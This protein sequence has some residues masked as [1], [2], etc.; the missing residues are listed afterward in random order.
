M[1]ANDRPVPITSCVRC[2]G[3][4]PARAAFC[5][6]CGASQRD[7]APAGPVLPG[8]TVI[9]RLGSGGA[10]DVYLAC[11]DDLDREV[12]I[13][14]L[15]R[16]VDDPKQWRR[17][18]RE[19]QTIARLSS[20]PH[21]VTVHTA[22]RAS[23]GQPYLV[24]E[25]LDRGSLGD[26]V[27]A[28]GPLAP[29]RAARVGVAVADALG[30]AHELGI[31]HRDVK[32]GN[33]LLAD[34]G[35]VKLG[36]FGI[37]RLLEAQSVTVT[38]VIA[39]TPEHVPPELLRNEPDGPWSDVY[40][41]AST[42]A[43]ALL[44]RSLF[45]M[46]PDERVD[47]FLARKVTSPPPALP[48]WVPPVLAEPI[49]AALD[50]DPRRRP[51]LPE[52]RRDLAAAADELSRGTSGPAAGTPPEHVLPTELLAPATATGGPAGR[53][54]PPPP[55]GSPPGRGGL[56]GDRR[57]RP[58]ARPATVALVS[59]LA[60]LALGAL[61][62][63]AAGLIGPDDPEAAIPSTTL[64]PATTSVP[65]STAPAADAPAAAPPTPVTSSP[66][67]TTPAATTSR[68]SGPA[69]LT[70]TEAATYLRSYYDAVAAG[71]YERTWAQLA[72]EFQTGT[73]RSFDYYVGFWEENDI[74]VGDVELVEADAERAVVDA[75]LR[76]NGSAD[77]V[78]ARFTLRPGADGTLLIADQETITD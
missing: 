44:A 27:A 50:P 41:L 77:A 60:L 45:R 56:G 37:A 54:P 33:V 51:S 24:T 23:T 64:G 18:Q 65:V 61:A 69:L 9:R 35:R 66:S 53:R 62:A 68:P 55:G 47:A 6:H 2:H 22:G 5:P 59:L 71:D 16:D 1:A 49:I 34:D 46:G 63:V 11:Q 67:T 17:F 21:V 38:D 74:E 32:P 4:I 75:E 31:L 7:P 10:A 42:V 73:A 15:R 48:A 25:Y 8:Y 19:A 14:V 29:E 39:F 78:V 26:V 30:A 58:P 70:A 40:G 36:D 3:E 28:D 20:H 76:W 12:A 57:R 13:K 52:L 43:S 72:P